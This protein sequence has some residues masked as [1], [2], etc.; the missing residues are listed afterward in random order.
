[1]G[2]NEDYYELLGVSRDAT[3]EQIKKAYRKQA[4]RYHPDR[5]AD[6]KGAE[7]KFK[8][9]AE[10][11]EVLSDPQKREIYDRHGKE[12]LEGRGYH[13]G[14]S[15]FEDVF[16]HFGDLFND[17]FGF[18]GGRARRRHAADLRV[19]AVLS[20]EEAAF[21]CK[22]DLDVRRSVACEVCRGAGHPPS[23]P[24]QTCRTC[25]GHGKV[26]HQQ[27]FFTLTSV[28]PTCGGG[29]AVLT[30]RCD[31]CAGKGVTQESRTLSVD[32]PAGVDTG[33]NL[34]LK[35][36]G[37]QGAGE[38]LSGDLYVQIV[39]QAHPLFRREGVD[40]AAEI[41]V[42]MVDA[43]LGTE[44]ELDLLGEGLKVK[45]PEGTQPGHVTRMRGKGF[46]RLREPGRGDLY[47]QTVV[48]VPTRLNR[49][50]KKLLKEFAKA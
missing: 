44:I 11:Y 50:Q 9:A 10:A 25:K 42:S 4:L 23:A 46:P 30:E 27:G 40:L 41:P 47:V 12:G 3:P 45:L 16:S 26:M 38:V 15:G 48:K 33:N 18:G 35:G 13:T 17:I 21:G 1:M 32:I 5:N 34:V 24:P 39:V 49:K 22:R 20:F 37:D 14:F 6:D 8:Q 29:G 43:A 7:E 36:E 28:C 2:N 31:A 19:E